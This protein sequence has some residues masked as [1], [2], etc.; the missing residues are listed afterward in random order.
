M[1]VTLSI[2]L[3]FQSISIKSVGVLNILKLIH[4]DLP[5][6]KYKRSRFE[7]KGGLMTILCLFLSNLIYITII[8]CIF[9]ETRQ[10]LKFFT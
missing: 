6:C 4:Y 3:Y 10:N 7:D 5:F 9:D 2:I 8:H 1:Y